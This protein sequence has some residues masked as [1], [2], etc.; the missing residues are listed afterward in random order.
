MMEGTRRVALDAILQLS[1]VVLMTE[2]EA[3]V[4]TGQQ[5][6]EAAARSILNRPNAYTQWCIVKVSSWCT[7]LRQDMQKNRVS[8][9][10]GQEKESHAVVHCQGEFP[11]EA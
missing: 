5:H 6:A 3:A 4:I 7:S 8:H 10:F 2:E 9:A 11:N 1:A